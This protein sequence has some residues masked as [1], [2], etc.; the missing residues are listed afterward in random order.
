M[1]DGWLDGFIGRHGCTLKCKSKINKY[2]DWKN[3]ELIGIEGR[4]MTMMMFITTARQD[5]YLTKF[6]MKVIIKLKLL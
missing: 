4:M 6:L 5:Y 2:I 3:H 1:M